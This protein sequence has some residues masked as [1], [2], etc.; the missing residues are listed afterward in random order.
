MNFRLLKNRARLAYRIHQ[1]NRK[2]GRA[3]LI[4]YLLIENKCNLACFY[5]FVDINNQ[6][7]HRL[8]TQQVFD[9]ID[10]LHE[11]GTILVC[12]MGGEPLLRKDCGEIIDYVHSKGMMCEMT[13]NALLVEQRF[14]AVKKLDAMMISLDGDEEANSKSRGPKAYAKCI[15]AIQMCLTEGIPVRV[16]TVLSRY[17]RDSF[18]HILELGKKHDFFVSLSI[19]ADTHYS[20]AKVVNPEEFK[21]NCLKDDEIREL[22]RVI[23]QKKREGYPVLFSEYTL[24]NVIGYPE[25]YSEILFEGDPR[26]PGLKP[27]AC[28]YGRLMAYVDTDGMVYPCAYQWGPNFKPKS[29]LAVGFQGAW[30]NVQAQLK[31][32]DCSLSR[33]AADEWEYVTSPQGMARGAYVTVKQALRKSPA[34]VA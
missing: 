28:M 20:D 18:H 3:P 6:E 1:L 26:R 15:Q 5:C 10:Q 30:D 21:K 34:P 27:G 7:V 16:N 2:G 23:L 33:L 4:A 19:M 13:T 11:A 8:T 24:K 14:D 29:W 31:C 22:Y 25:P 17:N 32:V 9:I 12:L